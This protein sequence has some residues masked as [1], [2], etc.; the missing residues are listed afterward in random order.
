[1]PVAED[2]P[3]QEVVVHYW[4]SARAAAGRGSD[5]VTAGTLAAVLDQVRGLRPGDQRFAR[6]VSVCSVLV[7]QTPVGTRDH[8]EVTVAPG[9]VVELLPPFAGG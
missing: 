9:S 5:H 2:A 4:A 3:L 7:D 1:M 6:V 8:A